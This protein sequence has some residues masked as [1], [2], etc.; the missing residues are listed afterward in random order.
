[1]NKTKLESTYKII[2]ET[3]D[4]NL[5]KLYWDIALYIKA[6][7]GVLP[8]EWFRGI[9]ESSINLEFDSDEII[10]K[11]REYYGKFK[12]GEFDEK[13]SKESS[14]DFQ[15]MRIY[16]I[17][18][19]GCANTRP[20]APS[21]IFKELLQDKFSYVGTIRPKDKMVELFNAEKH[22]CYV[23]LSESELLNHQKQF[24][25]D[26][27]NVKQFASMYN[28]MVISTYVIWYLIGTRFDVSGYK[29]IIEG[30]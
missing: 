20:I 5:R 17:L 3:K 6:L 8:S 12:D 10:N 23:G 21:L 19:N 15:S 18:G 2:T 16:Q 14:C 29:A 24:F 13:L 4:K 25:S 1:M 9:I 27:L 22:F 28:R 7:D 26:L 30:E 11:L